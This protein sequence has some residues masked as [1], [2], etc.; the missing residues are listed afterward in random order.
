MQIIKLPNPILREKSEP[1]HIPLTVEDRD[2]L[3]S[4]YRYVKENQDTALGISAVQIGQL[5]RLCAIKYAHENHMVVYQLANP[6]IIGHSA[7]KYSINGGEGCLSVNQEHDNLIPRWQSI[8]VYAY[9][10][11]KNKYITFDAFDF[12]AAVLQH[13][14]DHLDGKLYID[15]ITK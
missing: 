2:I 6:K 12:D 15:Y 13:E 5:K 10:C 3:N 8:K 14:I 7:K 1:V 11:I 9:D 4:M